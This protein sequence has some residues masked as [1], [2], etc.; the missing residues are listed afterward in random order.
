MIMSGA[1]DRGRRSNGTKSANLQRIEQ[2]AS[3]RVRT[4]VIQQLTG[5]DKKLIERVRKRVNQKRHSSRQRARDS[6][7]RNPGKSV[8]MLAWAALERKLEAKRKRLAG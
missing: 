4:A 2:L 3:D 7:A 1:Q 6:E 8:E 5:A